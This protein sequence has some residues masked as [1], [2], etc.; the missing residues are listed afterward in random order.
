MN[1]EFVVVDLVIVVIFRLSIILG[2]VLILLVG[3]FKG[4]CVVF[5]K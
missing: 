3:N 4:K 5:L 1:E 2:I